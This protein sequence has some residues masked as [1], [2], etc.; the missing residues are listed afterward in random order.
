MNYTLDIDYN[1]VLEYE[2]RQK[3]L[4]MAEYYMPSNEIYE[5]LP[6]DLLDEFWWPRDVIHWI[7]NWWD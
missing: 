7:N 3:T 4:H 6:E 1:E 2:D 5:V